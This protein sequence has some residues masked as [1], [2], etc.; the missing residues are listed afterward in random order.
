MNCDLGFAG[1]YDWCRYFWAGNTDNPFC[2]RLASLNWAS[3]RVPSSRGC[4]SCYLNYF[5]SLKNYSRMTVSRFRTHKSPQIKGS[6]M[7]V[8]WRNAPF[9]TFPNCATTKLKDHWN[10]NPLVLWPGQFDS[11]CSDSGGQCCC[12][13]WQGLQGNLASGRSA[14]KEAKHSWMYTDTGTHTLA[15]ACLIELWCGMHRAMKFW[16]ERRN[17]Q[18]RLSTRR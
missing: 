17:N 12:L 14:M 1:C 8:K 16:S 18:T 7:T 3:H 4:S 2:D 13:V 15:Q 11:L 10:F 5:H 9:H 6:K